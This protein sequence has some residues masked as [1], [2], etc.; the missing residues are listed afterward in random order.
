MTVTRLGPNGG[1]IELEEVEVPVPDLKL[2]PTNP[3]LDYVVKSRFGGSSRVTDAQLHEALWKEDYVKQL[4]KAIHATKGLLEAPILRH[5]NTVIEGNCRTV[6][7]R[8]LKK[9]YPN[10]PYWDTV[11]VHR[12]PAD[13]SRQTLLTM[14]I[15][16][17]IAGKTEWDAYEQART[18]AECLREDFTWDDVLAIARI[19]R[20]RLQ[21]TLKAYEL[22]EEFL[23]KY[24]DPGNVRKYS[25]FD[26]AIAKKEVKLRIEEPGGEFKHK[27]FDWVNSGRLNDMRQVRKLPDILRHKRAL[28]LFEK[29][30]VD[31]A[32]KS[33]M[34][35]VLEAEPA[36]SSRLFAAIEAAANELKAAPYEEIKELQAGNGAAPKTKAIRD[37]YHAIE[38]FAQTARIKL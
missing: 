36:M 31:N 4:A 9:R 24:P 27:F 15:D 37:L 32:F 17:H 1:R 14:L 20:G 23:K 16:M 10:E 18:L 33:A 19:S 13:V 8:E 21:R 12:F 26:E 35:A 38:D 28:D 29:T 30:P 11:V 25:Y 34:G 2:D 5:D 7:L 22:T 3:R 6:C